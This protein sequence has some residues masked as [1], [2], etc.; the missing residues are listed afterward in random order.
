MDE[1]VIGEYNRVETVDD[2]L[3]W[4]ANNRTVRLAA[5]LDAIRIAAK[6]E[7]M[8]PI[9]PALKKA[10]AG[11]IGYG[12]RTMSKLAAMID[13]PEDCIVPDVK[14]S[15]YWA[16]MLHSET[17]VDVIRHALAEG[18]S[19]GA[20]VKRYLGV[21]EERQPPLLVSEVDIVE[22][23]SGQMVIRDDSINPEDG[24][25]DRARVRIGHARGNGREVTP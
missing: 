5:Y 1:N 21:L 10:I 2:V 4:A 22:V 16:A 17:P 6:T 9:E 23:E 11:H 20:E 14:P 25:P 3:Q 15:F 19:T 18:W 12:T 8:S 13:L 7:E 24:W